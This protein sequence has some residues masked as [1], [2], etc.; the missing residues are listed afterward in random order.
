V[1]LGSRSDEARW[2]NEA[3]ARPLAAVWGF[4]EATLFFVVPDVALSFLALR[5]RQVALAACLWAFAGALVGGTVMYSWGRASAVTAEAALEK[6]P[7]I[8]HRMIRR[9]R[10]EL[11]E[12]GAGAVV[13][14]PLK[15]TPYKVYAVEAGARGVS[16]LAVLA[17]S[18]PSRL[19]RFLGSVLVVSLVARYPLRKWS[20]DRQRLTLGLFWLAVYLV[21]MLRTPG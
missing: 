2:G 21:L 4:A 6:V 12:M 18:V 7:A 5:S 10:T 13:L 20:L 16:P 3:L 19:G 11:D 17:A 15:T 1:D 8:D 14:G 9:V